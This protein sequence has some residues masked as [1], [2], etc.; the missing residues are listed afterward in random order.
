MLSIFV[1]SG[2]AGPALLID[3]L[4]RGQSRD[5]LHHH[6]FD[7]FPLCPSHNYLPYLLFETHSHQCRHFVSSLYYRYTEI[8]RLLIYLFSYVVSKFRKRVMHIL[9]RI[10]F[11]NFSRDK[12][13]NWGVEIRKLGSSAF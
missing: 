7:D 9:C 6:H 5:Q 11:R 3:L 1:T 12:F 8:K 2:Q 10:E 13:G 4:D